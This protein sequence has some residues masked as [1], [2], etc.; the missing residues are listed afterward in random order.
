MQCGVNK[1]AWYGLTQLPR[2]ACY[3]WNINIYSGI[4]RAKQSYI[5]YG[6]T[7]LFHAM[8]L[9]FHPVRN[10]NQHMKKITF[11][12]LC[13][14]LMGGLPGLAMAAPDHAEIYAAIH[15][16]L[17][18]QS[19]IWGGE[20]RFKVGEID[21]RIKLADCAKLEIFWPP[22]APPLGNSTVGV[23]CPEAPVN[24][25]TAVNPD[26]AVNPN[27]A[28]KSATAVEPSAVATGH[29]KK[30][31][32]RKGTLFVPV[33]ITVRT[34]VLIT[35]QALPQGHVLRGEDLS[36]QQGELTQIG[37]LTDAGLATG[38]VLKYSLS[39]G[40]ILKQDML[41]A[42]YAVTQGQTVQLQVEGEGFKVSAAGQALN[43]AA[44]GQTTKVKMDS[45]LVVGGVAPADGA[46]IVHPSTH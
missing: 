26:T 46:V 5:P 3:S 31:A 42:P 36:V 33:K 23:R 38:K 18:K 41:R 22:G 17:Q 16:F 8:K 15:V 2:L 12:L 6:I 7:P 21:R 37:I 4:K 40:Q 24:P 10:D 1:S 11:C 30:V 27:T 28:V 44:A 32:T 39:A 9:H 13:S 19:H 34:H 20:V 35:R 29:A 45:G 43:N 25:I 14:L